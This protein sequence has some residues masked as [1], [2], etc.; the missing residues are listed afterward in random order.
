M[1]ND[2]KNLGNVNVNMENIVDGEYQGYSESGPIKAEVYV[3]NH[4]L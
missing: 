4:K 3:E 2:S 1:V